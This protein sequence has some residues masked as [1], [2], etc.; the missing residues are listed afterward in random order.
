MANLDDKF[1]VIRGW[2]PGGDASVDQTESELPKRS[3]FLITKNEC[4]KSAPVATSRSRTEV[5]AT[6][7]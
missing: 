5:E 2:E 6:T 1:D 7:P 3:R 4:R